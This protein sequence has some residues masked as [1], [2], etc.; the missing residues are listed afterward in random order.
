MK[1]ILCVG[2]LVAVLLIIT[3]SAAVAAGDKVRGD[4]GEGPVNQV[5]VQDPLPFQ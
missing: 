2:V 5:Q 4:K 3:A 1:R